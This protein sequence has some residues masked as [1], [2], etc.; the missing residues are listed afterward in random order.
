MESDPC[1]YETLNVPVHAKP[2]HIKAAYRKLARRYHPDRA[3]LISANPQAREEVP[4][5]YSHHDMFSLVSRAYEVL[6]D[7]AQRGAYDLLRGITSSS[8]DELARVTE[9]QRNNARAA[10]EMMKITFD[11]KLRGEMARGGI[12]IDNAVYGTPDGI[13]AHLKYLENGTES[14]PK[15]G[16]YVNVTRQLQCLV[17]KSR[18]CI[19][20]GDP[21]HVLEAVYDPAVGENKNLLVR[22][23]FRGRLH[24]AIVG[25]HD[26]LLLP[27]KTHLIKRGTGV[28]A[29]SADK[30]VTPRAPKRHRNSWARDEQRQRSE[31]SLVGP[32]FLPRVMLASSGFAVV[33]GTCAYFWAGEEGDQW[34]NGLLGKTTTAVKSSV[35]WVW[36]KAA[37]R[38]WQQQPLRR[39][40]SQ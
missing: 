31:P 15:I 27:L 19:P 17:N 34:L 10:L 7:P 32:K 14:A 11:L 30:F 12:V 29:P 38:T 28:A 1:Y 26:K 40:A 36:G 33:V 21:K 22:Y 18:L 5:G 37:A 8:K 2:G 24:Q 23:Y 4:D 9:I 20:S 25:D 39:H 6:K 3:R 35:N 13:C 16:P